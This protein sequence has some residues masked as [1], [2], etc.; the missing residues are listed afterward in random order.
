MAF[1]GTFVGRCAGDVAAAVALDVT[2]RVVVAVD[3]AVVASFDAAMVDVVTVEVAA[4]A[5]DG[6]AVGRV[7]AG[8]VAIVAAA[9]AALV[10]V[11]ALRAAA[12]LADGAAAIELEAARRAAVACAV[13]VAIVAVVAI[14]GFTRTAGFVVAGSEKRRQHSE[15]HEPKREPHARRTMPAGT[16]TTSEMWPNSLGWCQQAARQLQRRV[17]PCASRTFPVAIKIRSIVCH[18]P[19]PPQVRSFKTPSAVWPSKKRSMPQLPAS[20]PAKST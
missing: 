10:H 2:L 3:D 12:V 17:L 20:T 8:Y 11:E 13:D 15:R 18:T 5:A 6:S 16:D 14:A 7:V 19:S 1:H 9:G 4:I